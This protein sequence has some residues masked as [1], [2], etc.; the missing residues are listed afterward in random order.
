MSA[1]RYKQAAARY[2]QAAQRARKD[3]KGLEQALEAA[4]ARLEELE[5]KAARVDELE[6]SVGELTTAIREG[7]A[8]AAWEEQAEAAGV[9]PAHFDALWTLDPYAHEGDEAPDPKALKAHVAKAL[10]ANPLYAPAEGEGEPEPEEGALGL[11]PPAKG[12]APAAGDAPAAEGGKGAA[13]AAGGK[14]PAPAAGA[15]ATALSRGAGAGRGQRD[16]HKQETIADLVDRDYQAAGRDLS[17]PFK[18]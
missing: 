9:D 11:A 10:K 3:G 16:N 17:N 4:L 6:A 5:P 1:N 13:P 15:R 2:K 12:K 7:A 8:R 14:A 18:I